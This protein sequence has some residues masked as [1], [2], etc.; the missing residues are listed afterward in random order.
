MPVSFQKAITKKSYEHVVSQIQEAIL[1][2]ELQE[3]ERL[4]SEMKLKDMFETSRG[5]IREALRVLEQKGLVFIKTGVKGGATVKQAGIQPISDGIGLLI[6]QRKVPL[7]DL[8]QFRMLLEGFVTFQAAQR[9]TQ[10][11][12]SM[13]GKILSE[14]EAHL[15]TNP[16]SFELFN[17]MDA[18]FHQ[19]LAKIADNL[20]VQANLKTIHENIHAYFHQYLP[21]NAG[22]LKEDFNDLEQIYAAITDNDPETAKKR[23]EDHVMRFTALMEQQM[24]KTAGVSQ[25]N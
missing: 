20:L 9:A 14:I 5:T 17:R 18:A 2:G 15:A 24:N 1:S 3:G 12:K 10:E 6:A 23:A 7:S 19:A 16:D 21:F 22:I 25:E 4:P 8:A 11:D 13:L